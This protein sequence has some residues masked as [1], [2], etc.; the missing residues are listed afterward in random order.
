MRAFTIRIHRAHGF[1]L[2]EVLVS[3]AILLA[4]IL[5]IINFFPMTLKAS[6][7]A[8]D[9]SKAVLLAQMKAEEIR[10]DN[11]TTRDYI[12]AIKTLPSPTNPTVFPFEQKLSYVFSGTSQLDPDDTTRAAWV[13]IQYS[14]S[15]DDSE[16][17]IYELK[18]AE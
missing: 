6:N 4:G 8:V 3:L 17:V 15:F 16:K 13:V 11:S 14:A 10:R 5:T 12:T 1:S 7:Q 2:V 9:L 18:F